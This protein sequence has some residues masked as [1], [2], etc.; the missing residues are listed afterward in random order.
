MNRFGPYR[1]AIA[2]A[3]VGLLYAIGLAVAASC[4]PPPRRALDPADGRASVVEMGFAVQIAAEQCTANARHLQRIDER[5]SQALFD[6]CV[7]ALIPA[8]DAVR[9]VLPDVEPWTSKSAAAVACTGKA[10]R[11]ALERVRE[12]FIAAG[13]AG[14]IPD[15]MQDGITIGRRVEP[16]ALSSC[17]PL[18]PTTRTTTYIDPNI[19]PVDP[20]Y[21]PR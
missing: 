16:S 10:V 3:A 20:E 15:V 17:D 8:R 2:W 19:A 4:L 6:D 21:P 14:P 5:R 7:R 11:T 12:L 9:F 13:Y 1:S 18:H